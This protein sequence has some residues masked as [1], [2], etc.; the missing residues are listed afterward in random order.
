MKVLEVTG[1]PILHGGQEQ[2]IRNLID[3]VHYHQARIDVL[4]PYIC[5]N[6]EFQ[7]TVEEK[8]GRVIALGLP[9]FRG[10]S[11][12]LLYEPIKSLLKRERYDVVHIHSGSISALAYIAKAASEAGVKKIIVHS[13]STA[14]QSLKHSLVRTVYGC[15]L[16]KYPTDYLAC[17]EEAGVD[18]FPARIVKN[19][20]IIIKN[21][22]SIK[23]YRR[24]ETQRKTQRK[25]LGIPDD[26]FVIGHVGR[27]AYEKNHEFIIDLFE[28]FHIKTP[29]SILLLV[30][31]GEQKERVVDLVNK[32]EIKEQVIFTGN[33]DNVQDYYQVMDVFVLPSLY[34][35][36]PYVILEAQAAGLPCIISTGVPDAVMIGKNIVKV[37]LTDK[38]QWLAAIRSAREEGVTDNTE[39]IIAAGF[40]ANETAKSV[41]EIYKRGR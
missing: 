26:A 22:I 37:D 3:N 30:G 29:D 32:K 14:V 28:E 18:K 39:A 33:V 6:E 16:A 23:K 1:E 7:K 15:F 31:D 25:I 2:F 5:D 17:S 9:F 24:D 13:H 19:R 41:I 35:G 8:G 11:R 40:D 21:G 27:F 10:K 38:W 34:E 20:L 4:T 36:F 12:K